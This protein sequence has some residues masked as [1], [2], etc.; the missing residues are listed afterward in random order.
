MR[1]IYL[2][3]FFH[4][5]ERSGGTFSYDLARRLVDRGH[6][7]RVVT[8]DMH[9]L[10]RG[11]GSRSTRGSRSIGGHRLFEPHVLRPATALL[12]PVCLPRAAAACLPGD[13]L[14]VSPPLTT[15]A[16]DHAANKK[17]IPRAG[18]PRSLAATAIARFAAAPGGR[19]RWM[20]YAYRT[21]AHITG[22]SSSRP[23][24]WLPRRA[25]GEGH[26][27][28]DA[29]RRGSVPRAG[30]E[31]ERFAAAAP[32]SNT[33]PWSSI[34]ARSAWSWLPVPC[35]WLPPRRRDPQ[36]SW[37]RRP[38]EQIIRRLAEQLGVLGVN[39]FIERPCCGGDL[40][41]PLGRRSGHLDSHRPRAAWACSPANSSTPGRRPADRHQ[42]PGCRVAHPRQPLRHGLGR[43]PGR[44]GRRAAD[45]LP[46][47]EARAAGSRSPPRRNTVRRGPQCAKA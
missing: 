47:H 16:C 33:G 22:T 5:P 31:G 9:A 21:A 10:H 41:N 19:R 28:P 34:P 7:V 46:E 15:R 6:E 25:L 40:R 43:S 13:V 42:S 32:G 12:R 4:T 23:R 27:Y 18:G 45:P 11:G 39:L 20:G 44:V 29:E 37:S 24:A 35:G 26:L 2:H 36:G 17:G 38:R 8:S 30:H 14:Y 1:I 3:Q